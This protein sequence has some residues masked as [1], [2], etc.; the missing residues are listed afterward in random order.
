MSIH[1]DKNDFGY[2]NRDSKDFLDL[3]SQEKNHIAN[4]YKICVDDSLVGRLTFSKLIEEALDNSDSG[5][6]AFCLGKSY[7]HTKVPRNM[8]NSMRRNLLG[9]LKRI[10]SGA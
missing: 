2:I 8:S 3:Y 4:T 10:K 6:K 7:F 5:R 9:V 1:L